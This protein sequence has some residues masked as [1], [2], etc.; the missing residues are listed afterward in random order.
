MYANAEN[1]WWLLINVIKYSKCRGVYL[2]LF[3]EFG[4]LV[5]R[6]SYKFK[7][8]PVLNLSLQLNVQ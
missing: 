8:L 4:F 3:P 2:Q 7:K 5:A 6:A 1:W